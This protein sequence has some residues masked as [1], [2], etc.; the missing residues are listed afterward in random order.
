MN[1]F[2]E[3]LQGSGKST[4]VDKLSKLKTDCCTVKEGDYSQ[5]ELAWCAY[6]DEQ[7]Y[8]DKL[9][10][11]PDMKD[12]IEAN[13]YKENDKRIVCYTKI[14]TDNR[15]F[16]KDLEQYEIYNGRVSYE[17]FKQ[18]VFTRL[19][20]W[21]QDNMIYEC[22]LFQNIVEDMILY[23]CA[24]DD[25]IIDFYKSIRETLSDKDYHVFYLKADDIVG[26]L[27]VIRKERSDDKGNEIWFPLMIDYFDNSP[28]AKEKGL[29]GEDAL[30][31]H[32]IHRQELELKICKEI[33]PDKCT[34][35][36]SKNYSDD[37]LSE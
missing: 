29:K 2:V 12:I 22:S 17:D 20:A 18:I 36:S 1:Y 21:N 34:V 35:I 30:I 32:F 4:L 28:Y 16:Y 7:T 13:T 6:M 9:N 14:R 24:S 11:Y 33:F 27:N 10:T 23:R 3:G 31:G 15:D 26:N 8:Q 5:I 19:K 37:E 25:E